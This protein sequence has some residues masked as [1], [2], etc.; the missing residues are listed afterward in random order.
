MSKKRVA[1]ACAGVALAARLGGPASNADAGLVIDLRLP[2]ALS[3][4][5][6]TL[7]NFPLMPKI[8]IDI[9]AVVTGTDTAVEGFQS[10]QG[11]ILTEG[12]GMTGRILPAGDLD[13]GTESIVLPARAPF[14]NLG[15][16]PGGQKHIAPPGSS[17]DDVLDLG[18]VPAR[19]D[20]GDLIVFR[21]GNMQL[22]GGATPIPDGREYRIGTV[23]LEITGFQGPPETRINWYFRT[24]PSGGPVDEAVLFRQDGVN[25]FGNTGSYSAGSPIFIGA[26][27]EP[28]VFGGVAIVAG[29]LVGRR[30]RTA[31][32]FA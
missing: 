1:R 3:S 28:G 25:Y 5:R 10:V 30:G 27:P 14:N 19:S 16:A 22:S 9:Y 6:K 18:D 26:I 17:A 8:P 7:T 32:K 11:A 29:M 15:A 13:S 21:S 23:E 24:L 4:D 12:R 20:L 2:S 31:R